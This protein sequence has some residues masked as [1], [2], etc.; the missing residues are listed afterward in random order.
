MSVCKWLY[1]NY[2]N[3]FTFLAEVWTYCELIQLVECATLLGCCYSICIYFFLHDT[4]CL[5]LL[6]V[7]KAV[8][9]FPF[10]L[11]LSFPPSLPPCRPAP[12]SVSSFTE[13]LKVTGTERKGEGGREGQREDTSQYRLGLHNSRGR[14]R[15]GG[16]KRKERR[17]SRKVLIGNSINR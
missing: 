3:L 7:Y 11:F 13:Q 10:S 17:D 8:P 16:T 5:F 12:G 9:L 2:K 14:A 1:V 4:K 15:D 6:S